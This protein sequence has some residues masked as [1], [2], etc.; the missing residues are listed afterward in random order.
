MKNNHLTMLCLALLLLASLSVNGKAFKYPVL[1]Q[2][3]KALNSFLPRGWHLLKSAIGDLNGD[4]LTDVAAVFESNIDAE[5]NKDDSMGRENPRILCI[6]FRQKAGGYW[7]SAQGNDVIK[8]ADEGGAFGD[9]FD[10]IAIKQGVLI[11]H[12]YGGSNWRFDFTT[13]F[14]FQ[15]NKWYLIGITELVYHDVD[16]TMQEYDYNLLT[17]KMTITTG[18]YFEP[19]KQTVRWKE[20]GKR[21]V[22][23]GQYD[24]W[25]NGA[26]QKIAPPM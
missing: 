2:H 4:K 24:T 25:Y 20:I 12:F 9:P 26:W 15:R 11:L 14:R 19:K 17:G 5:G 18:N 21:S 13:K 8:T 6:L 1:R 7:L 22:T 3:G 16:G 23:L 10:K